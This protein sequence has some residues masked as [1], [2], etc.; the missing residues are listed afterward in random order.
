MKRTIAVVTTSRA[1]YSHL[2]W[3]LKDLAAHPDV[4]LKL[5]VL[6]AHLSPEF[7][8]T[9]SEIERDGFVIASRIEC[10]LSSDSDVGMAKTLGLAILGLAD[11]L[12]QMRPDLLLLIADRYEMLGPA[13]VALTLRIP[14]AHI[15]GGEIS[16]G[17]IDDAVRN[18]LTKMAHIHF[19]STETARARVISMGEE[20]WRVHRAGAPSLDHLR[21]STLPTRGELEEALALQLADE[22]T[23][24]A[25]HPVTLFKET[26]AEA[27]AVFAALEEVRGQI[28]FCY[29]N[30][31]AGSHDL[32]ARIRGFCARHENAHLF[33]NLPSIT[34]W[35]LLREATCMV[36]NS[37]SGIMEAASFALPVVNVGM[38]QQGR[39]RGINILDAEATMDSIREQLALS[40]DPAF[41]ES[42]R[43]A[44]NIYGNGH[45]AERIVAVL[46]STPL[47]SL[48]HKRA[49]PLPTELGPA[50]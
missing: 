19:T 2:Y 7:G 24:V 47:E 20:A 27:D 38:R 8:A 13:S 29:P 6:A 32:M 40:R 48:L 42:V 5:I 45:A 14:V 10:L 39:E 35:A 11:T 15:E 30:A 18:A 1:D 4:D 50:L 16:E 9:V 49:Q 17:A 28:I 33:V 41:I 46:T 22:I 3:P 44:T 26:T 34:Y 23:V 43:T 12:A 36:G 25:Y 37:S 21:R 31:D